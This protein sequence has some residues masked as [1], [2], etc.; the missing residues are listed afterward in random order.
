MTR[1]FG[2]GMASVCA[3]AGMMTLYAHCCIGRSGSSWRGG[4]KIYIALTGKWPGLALR[5]QR[6][7]GSVVFLSK[8][9]DDW[10]HS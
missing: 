2:I 3:L 9:P 10:L 4:S 5:L 1:Y 8:G 6:Q 7:M